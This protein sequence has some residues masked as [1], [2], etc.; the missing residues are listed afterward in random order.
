MRAIKKSFPKTIDFI[1]IK[2][3][4][5]DINYEHQ[6]ISRFE[7]SIL[8]TFELIYENKEEMVKEIEYLKN[9][10]QE[11]ENKLKTF[12]EVEGS[13]ERVNSFFEELT[14]MLLSKNFNAKVDHQVISWMRSVYGDKMYHKQFESSGQRKKKI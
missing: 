14:S 9:K 2:F 8:K 3:F 13:L 10:I 12:A 4:K 1:K 11:Q 6:I 7:S 5:V